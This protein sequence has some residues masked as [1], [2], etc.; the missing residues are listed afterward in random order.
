MLGKE[1][2]DL[3]N[4]SENR[5]REKSHGISHQRMGK[6]LMTQ[7]ELAVMD[8]SKCIFQ[9]RGERPFLSN[10]Y[11][12]TKHPNYRYLSDADPNQKFN[13]NVELTT[14]QSL[15]SSEFT[16]IYSFEIKAEV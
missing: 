5:G 6:D 7:D 14:H 9:L 15:N 4:T 2:I 10:K 1:T 12:I 11:D 3:E 16:D 13:I 8:N